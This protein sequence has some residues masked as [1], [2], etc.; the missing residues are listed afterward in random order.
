MPTGSVPIDSCV[1]VQMNLLSESFGTDFF[2]ARKTTK[3]VY[4]IV[5]L[6]EKEHRPNLKIKLKALS[7]EPL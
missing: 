2:E 3:D 6:Q 7:S 4:C 5:A 1:P